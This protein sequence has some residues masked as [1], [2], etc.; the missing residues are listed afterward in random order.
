MDRER[1]LDAFG[2]PACVCRP[3]VDLPLDHARFARRQS[4]YPEVLDDLGRGLDSDTLGCYRTFVG[5]RRNGFWR[6][7]VA[8]RPEPTQTRP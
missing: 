2:V 5:E 7:F 3:R 1:L 6:T 4:T 8:N